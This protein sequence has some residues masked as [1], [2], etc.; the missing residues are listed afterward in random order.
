M[1]VKLAFGGLGVLLHR[2]MPAGTETGVPAGIWACQGPDIAR[3]VCA[4]I[5]GDGVESR[6]A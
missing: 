6:G 2:S 1:D 4:G 5:S 3:A